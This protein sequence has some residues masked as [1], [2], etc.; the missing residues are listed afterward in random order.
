[1]KIIPTAIPEVLLIEPKVFEDPRGFF[2]ETFREDWLPQLGINHTFIQ[3]NHSKS[4]KGVLRG[5]HFQKPPYEQAKLV[6]VTS[7]EVL[8]VAVDLRHGS[9]TF[10]KVAAEILSE[11]NRR[12]ML[13]PKG[14]AQEN[15]LKSFAFRRK[16]AFRICSKASGV[17]L[18]PNK[19]WELSHYLHNR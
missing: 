2:M 18:L 4:V 16:P 14:F 7:G 3:D 12:M 13:V 8:D 10:G 1:M 15:H 17:R 19:N 11:K 5:L 6:R 9:P